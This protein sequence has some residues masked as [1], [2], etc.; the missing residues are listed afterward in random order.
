VLG[1][2]F[3]RFLGQ[4][5]MAYLARWRLQLAARCLDTTQKTV[6]EVAIEVGYRSESA[7]NRAFKREFG[8]PPARY[9]KARR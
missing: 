7:F 6:L 4:S 3:K 2:R 5:P 1:K 8:L 9:R